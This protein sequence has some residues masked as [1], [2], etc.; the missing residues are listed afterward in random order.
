M[1]LGRRRDS[2]DGVGSARGNSV[3]PDDI[4]LIVGGLGGSGAHLLKETME[5]L[6]R[7]AYFD[8]ALHLAGYHYP[9]QRSRLCRHGEMV[10]R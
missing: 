9:D 6:V 3:S 10:W 5:S 8:G 2:F 1:N 4:L 7:G